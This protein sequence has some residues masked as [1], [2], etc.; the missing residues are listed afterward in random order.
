MFDF[1][2]LMTLV[3]IVNVVEADV[4]QHIFAE[5]SGAL[6]SALTQTSTAPEIKSGEVRIR[7]IQ[8]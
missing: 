3:G 7:T 1:A 5:F 4:Y 8:L 6:T 2:R